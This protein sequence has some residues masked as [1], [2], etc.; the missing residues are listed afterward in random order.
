M[1]ALVCDDGNDDDQDGFTLDCDDESDCWFEP[2]C[3]G[4]LCPNF[5]LVDSTDYVTP[6]NGDNITT[7]SLGDFTDSKDATCFAA[8]A[9]DVTFSLHRSQQRLRASVCPLRYGGCSVGSHDSCGGSELECNTGSSVAT[10]RFGTTYGAYIPLQMTTGEEYI[11]AVSGQN[12]SSDDV[13]L[14]IDRNDEV[15]CS[16]SLCRV[17][18][19]RF[20]LTS[21]YR[22]PVWGQ[23]VLR[24]RFDRKGY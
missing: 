4:S 17:V 7:Q 1:E 12:I 10:T 18:P 16:G 22:R 2:T 3:G 14:S 8:G 11:I 20:G 5:S 6:L 9:S 15:D 24:V 19:K 23:G 13:T 21:I